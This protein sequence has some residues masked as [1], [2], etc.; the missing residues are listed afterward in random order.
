[1]PIRGGVLGHSAKQYNQTLGQL[2]Q[3]HYICGTKPRLMVQVVKAE[4]GAR[5]Q[6]AQHVPSTSAGQVAHKAAYLATKA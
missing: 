2:E 6:A 4:K 1:M 5:G 3:Q